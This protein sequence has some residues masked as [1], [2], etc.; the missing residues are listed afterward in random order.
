MRA[1]TNIKK[2]RIPKLASRVETDSIKLNSK[3][4]TRILKTLWYNHD[5][6]E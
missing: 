6:D 3:S 1:N 4:S 5:V 2:D